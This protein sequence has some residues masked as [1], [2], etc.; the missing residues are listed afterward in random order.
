MTCDWYTAPDADFDNTRA[1]LTIHTRWCPVGFSD[2][3]KEW[4]TCMAKTT[5]NYWIDDPLPRYGFARGGNVT[6]SWL[7]PADYWFGND[8]DQPAK[9]YCSTFDTIGMPFFEQELPT[10]DMVTLRL[11]AGDDV[12]CDWYIYQTEDWA[13]G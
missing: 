7:E 3:G 13:F 4:Q 2:F 10:P 1:S 5:G 8:I 9:I 6:F 11:D 12:I